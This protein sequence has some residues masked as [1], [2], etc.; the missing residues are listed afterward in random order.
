MSSDSSSID[1]EVVK[2]NS[3]NISSIHR[4]KSYDS[5]LNSGD[6]RDNDDIIKNG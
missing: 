1:N 3:L 4:A 5:S 2:N 6:R